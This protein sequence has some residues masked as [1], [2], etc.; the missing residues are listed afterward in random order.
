MCVEIAKT[1]LEQ[2]GGNKFIVM[3]GAKNLLA[4][5]AGLSFKLPSRFAKS[6]INYVEIS[7]DPNDTYI[8]YFGKIFKH[9]ITDI[10]TYT[11]VY[12]DGLQSMFTENLR[13][14]PSFRAGMDSKGLSS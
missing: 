9:T 12:F 10:I 13:K 4:H 5:E 6:G 2:L 1:I 8:M 14:A 11:D 7:L 3:T